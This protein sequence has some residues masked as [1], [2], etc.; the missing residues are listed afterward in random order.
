MRS[1]SIRKS[2]Q[3]ASARRPRIVAGGVS[4]TRAR[5]R[6]ARLPAAA[7]ALG[8]RRGRVLRM[9]RSLGAARAAEGFAQQIFARGCKGR[10]R[11][12]RH[13]LRV[14]RVA[15]AM[16]RRG[17]RSSTRRKSRIGRLAEL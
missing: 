14:A 17:N 16:C 15:L 7:R 4:R 2:A 5:L 11:W 12:K 8:R 10:K 3:S 1:A 6:R 13:L 9:K